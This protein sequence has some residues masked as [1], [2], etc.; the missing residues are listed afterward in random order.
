MKK[1][2]LKLPGEP[3]NLEDLCFCV[4][5]RI[6]SR[7]PKDGIKHHDLANVRSGLE[8]T[9]RISETNKIEQGGKK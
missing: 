3:P 4:I 5:T 1:S 7:G 8:K 2:P 9:G 6:H